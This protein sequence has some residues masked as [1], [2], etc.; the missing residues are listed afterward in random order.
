MALE[1][2]LTVRALRPLLS[3]LEA[4]GHDPAVFLNRIGIRRLPLDDPDAQVPM[5][6]AVGLLARACADI[7]DENLG[8][9]LAQRAALTS[10]DVHFY[11]MASSRSSAPP[12]NG[13]AVISG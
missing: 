2:L 11:A 7:G 4:M 3:G 13:C 1:P 9:H 8:L 5:R 12:T 10:V 6:L